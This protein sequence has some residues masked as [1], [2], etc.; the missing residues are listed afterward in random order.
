LTAA[1]AAVLVKLVQSG[2]FNYL[3]SIVFATTLLKVRDYLGIVGQVFKLALQDI[4]VARSQLLWYKLL[5][6]FDH[7]L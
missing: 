3:D 7:V 4:F 6:F 2:F 1:H 5:E